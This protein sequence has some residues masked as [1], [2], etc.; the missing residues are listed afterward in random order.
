MGRALQ[1]SCLGPE[2]WA[3]GAGG[4][5][6]AGRMGS[7]CWSIPCPAWCLTGPQ[8]LFPGPAGFRAPASSG[9]CS[10]VSRGWRTFA[11]TFSGSK[12]ERT[13]SATSIRVPCGEMGC[14]RVPE[15]G[16]QAPRSRLLVKQPV[17]QAVL[18]V[19]P[20]REIEP[21]LLSCLEW[22]FRLF[23]P[24]SSEPSSGPAQTRQGTAPCAEWEGSPLATCGS[25]GREGLLLPLWFEPNSE[26]TCP[27]SFQHL[28]ALPAPQQLAQRLCPS[29]GAGGNPEKGVLVTETWLCLLLPPSM[30]EG[31]LNFHC[32]IKKTRSH[33]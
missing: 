5:W 2:P 15:P 20:G 22:R 29:L 19:R 24:A 21:Q 26:K 23:L 4:C 8:G 32:Q 6:S 9:R 18:L 11:T 28:Q 33:P 30:S 17:P 31:Y 14:S 13:S 27:G 16:F 12:L 1:S 10:G 7:F 25:T 3:L